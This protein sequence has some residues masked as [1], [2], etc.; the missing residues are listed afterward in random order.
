MNVSDI[1]GLIDSLSDLSDNTVCA[2]LCDLMEESDHPRREDARQI[3]EA[4]LFPWPLGQFERIAGGTWWRIEGWY[5]DAVFAAIYTPSPEAEAIRHL[6]I[7]TVIDSG[8]GEIVAAPFEGHSPAAKQLALEFV[9]RD[10]LAHL[11][12][13]TLLRV[14]LHPKEG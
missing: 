14:P 8:V 3:A 10:L 6:C 12:D 4:V 2:A 11:C 9:R 5:E 1:T 7:D 13:C